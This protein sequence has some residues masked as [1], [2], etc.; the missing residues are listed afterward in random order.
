M[1]ASGAFAAKR[2]AQAA[3]W[4]HDLLQE[5]LLAALYSD[6]ALGRRIDELEEDVAAGKRTPALAVAELLAMLGLARG[7][8]GSAP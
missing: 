8:L 6:A 2:R 3:A 5:R 4:M 1:T 7:S